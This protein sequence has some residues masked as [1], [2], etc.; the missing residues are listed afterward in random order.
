MSQQ[1]LIN[2]EFEV[3]LAAADGDRGL[4]PEH[5]TANHCHRF[6]LG[7]I[8]LAR[9]DRGTRFVVRQDQFAEAGT[10]TRAEQADVVGD[11][12]QAGRHRIAVSYTHL[13]AHE[14][15][16]YLVCRLLLE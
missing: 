4:V 16:S 7:R 2:I 8:D 14:T 5:L 1:R 6:A 9:H 13:R 3:S 11:L 12:E 15:D 10:R